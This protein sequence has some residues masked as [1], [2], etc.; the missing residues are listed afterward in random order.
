[1]KTRAIK[2]LL[3]YRAICYV[4]W[5]LDICFF[6]RWCMI[7]NT[8]I[9]LVCI[10]K[11]HQGHIWINFHTSSQA[12]PPQ[13]ADAVL[14]QRIIP[15]TC[16]TIMWTYTSWH[17]ERHIISLSSLKIGLHLCIN[18]TRSFGIRMRAFQRHPNQR[19]YDSLQ[20]VSSASFCCFFSCAFLDV[21]RWRVDAAISSSAA[22]GESATHHLASGPGIICCG[23]KSDRSFLVRCKRLFDHFLGN[24]LFSNRLFSIAAE[25]FGTTRSRASKHDFRKVELKPFW[26]SQVSQTS[27]TICEVAFE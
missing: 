13:L 6:E 5:N 23:L 12:S 2:V 8:N 27:H 10:R 1:M 14:L 3:F 24:L 9:Q 11:T 25:L 7:R 15:N 20:L 22:A 18:R 26:P 4:Q 16:T 21:G 17:V 19:L